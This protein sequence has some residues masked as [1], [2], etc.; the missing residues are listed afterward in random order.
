MLESSSPIYM[1]KKGKKKE[2]KK[3]STPIAH[4]CLHWKT[5]QHVNCAVRCWSHTCCLWHWHKTDL[6]EPACWLTS[7]RSLSEKVVI[8]RQMTLSSS[9][10]RHWAD[11]IICPFGIIWSKIT[12]HPANQ[13]PVR[14]ICPW[15]HRERSLE[16][17][18][19]HSHSPHYVTPNPIKVGACV[20]MSVGVFP[21]V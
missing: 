4:S 18:H 13:E 15:C 12:L 20:L 21:C 5:D 8:S 3:T 9:C 14:N 6:R 7:L 1:G 11:V 16:A 10:G 19:T 17:S 2:N